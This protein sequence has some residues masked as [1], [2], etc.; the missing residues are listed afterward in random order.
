MEFF[1]DDDGSDSGLDA[2]R[3]DGHDT[4][5]FAAAAAV[6]A[7]QDQV[8]ALQ[9]QV[10]A[11]V[12]LLANV[13]RPDA[14]TIRFSNVDVQIVNG[15][16]STDTVNGTGNLIV[17]YNELRGTGDNRSGSHNI[18]VGKAHNYS[19]YGGLVVAFQNSITAP[20]ASVTGGAYNQ[21]IGGGCS[22]SGG[23]NNQ[24][25]AP[26]VAYSSVSGGSGNEASGNTASIGGGILNKAT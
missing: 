7:L 1:F 15:L 13:T 17:G 12:A 23:S 26:G 8:A 25:G 6:T 14:N 5:Y 22:V 4:A 10:D 19:S 16:G 3:L 11:L 9:I 18:V 24:A 21:A 20:W 2:D